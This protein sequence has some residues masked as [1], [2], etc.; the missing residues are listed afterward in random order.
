M[1]RSYGVSVPKVAMKMEGPSWLVSV[2]VIGEVASL[3]SHFGFTIKD[4]H[5]TALALAGREATLVLH[6]LLDP[7]TFPL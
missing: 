7:R 4:V 6:D 5:L 3:L 1:A 2:K